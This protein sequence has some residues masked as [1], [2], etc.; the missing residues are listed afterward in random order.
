MDEWTIG[1]QA[2]LFENVETDLP[3]PWTLLSSLK[4]LDHITLI[5]TG[6]EIEPNSVDFHPFVSFFAANISKYK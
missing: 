4:I 6:V 2:R 3:S 5:S 1:R